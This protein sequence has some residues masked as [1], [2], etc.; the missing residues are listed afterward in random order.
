[1]PFSPTT[2]RL[3]RIFR[4]AAGVL[5]LCACG[6]DDGEVNDVGVADAMTDDTETND[7]GAEVA[8]E[9]PQL[10]GTPGE[11]TGLDDGV[12]QTSCSCGGDQ[13]I[14]SQPTENERANWRAWSPAEAWP[15]TA[16]NPYDLPAVEPET[17]IVCAL[18]FD[19]PSG[20]Y[21][22][23]SAREEELP[24]ELVLTHTG[25][26][27]A[28]SSLQDLAVYAGVPDLTTPVRQCGLEGARNGVEAAEAC[29]EEIGF[30]NACAQIWAFN[31]MNTLAVCLETCFALLSSP[32]HEEDGSPNACIQCDE[33]NS[34]PVFK[35][36]AGRTR[37]NSGLPTA[38]CR[39][40]DTVSQIRHEIPAAP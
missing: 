20:S 40:C 2:A 30:S 21:T 9:C 12:C 33:D 4:T 22:F 39:P 18:R 31:A 28:C 3:A 8:V 25:S 11:N 5:A 24:E 10:F 16:Q 36:I 6:A 17:G 29:I 14:P 13:W 34:G 7:A 15:R 1:M 38:L 23:V 32:Y 26:C 35:A 27:G 37:R 19:E